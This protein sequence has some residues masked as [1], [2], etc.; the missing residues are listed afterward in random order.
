[1]FLTAELCLS[2]PVQ[3]LSKEREQ[4]WKTIF[5]EFPESEHTRGINIQITPLCP[6]W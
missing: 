6:S 2:S 5:F 1:M 3:I 4:T